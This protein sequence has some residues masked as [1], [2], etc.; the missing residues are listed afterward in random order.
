GSG[1]HDG[2]RGLDADGVGERAG[3]RDEEAVLDAN[4]EGP[5]RHP[6]VLVTDHRNR[7]VGH[8]YPLASA[9][10][11]HERLHR[12]DPFSPFF[13]AQSAWS[14]LGSGQLAVSV[15]W[16]LSRGWEPLLREWMRAR[17]GH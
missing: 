3:R 10:S 9:V 11:P 4:A 1:L 17:E 14:T 15:I 12:L 5:H 7:Y 16:C 8:G 2:S 6:D 13:H